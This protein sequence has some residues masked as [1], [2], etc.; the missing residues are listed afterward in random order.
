MLLSATGATISGGR[1]FYS[2][3]EN[4][5]YRFNRELFSEEARVICDC[6]FDWSGYSV[7]R[8]IEVHRL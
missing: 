7:L 1:H 3:P 6:S 8:N 2:H 4:P 5:S